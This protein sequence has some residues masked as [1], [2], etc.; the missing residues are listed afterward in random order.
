M[1]NIDPLRG[2]TGAIRAQGDVP[3]A[4]CGRQPARPDCLAPVRRWTRGVGTLGVR[5][6]RALDRTEKVQ[7]RERCV[8]GRMKLL[9]KTGK[10]LYLS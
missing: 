2:L 9:A 3:S 6:F 8:I 5:C 4:G 10:P 7:D 1:T